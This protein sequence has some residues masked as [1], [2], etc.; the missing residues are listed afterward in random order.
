MYIITLIYLY[1]LKI[2][3]KVLSFDEQKLRILRVHVSRILAK[4]KK[5]TNS[6]RCKYVKVCG[7]WWLMFWYCNSH[8]PDQTD[9]TINGRL[10]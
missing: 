4:R 6:A 3:L 5:E 8:K 1:F 9:S 7:L 2:C 10:L